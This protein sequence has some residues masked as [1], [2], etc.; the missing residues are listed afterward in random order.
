MSTNSVM[1]CLQKIP[2]HWPYIFLHS[3]R[4]NVSLKEYN[5]LAN[6]QEIKNFEKEMIYS[7]QSLIRYQCDIAFFAKT[8]AKKQKVTLVMV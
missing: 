3:L 6:M 8:T 5:V 7:S 4:A 1:Y 2:F